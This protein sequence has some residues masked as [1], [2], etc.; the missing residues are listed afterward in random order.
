MAQML[1]VVMRMA[2]K[3]RTVHDIGSANTTA[4]TQGVVDDLMNPPA[5]FITLDAGTSHYSI[6]ALTNVNLEIYP[7]SLAPMPPRGVYTY[8]YIPPPII[9]NTSI[10]QMDDN[11]KQSPLI[12]YL[13]KVQ[14]N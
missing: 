8:L 1:Q 3:K 10:T 2:H 9:P 11:P 4:W 13:I 14:K 5:N 12:L 6:Q 7:S